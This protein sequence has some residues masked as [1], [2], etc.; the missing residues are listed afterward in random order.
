MGQ[1]TKF[2]TGKG[3]R[4]DTARLG[5]TERLPKSSLLIDVIGTLDEATCALGMARAHSQSTLMQGEFPE[6]Q[7]RLYRLMSH[8]SATPATRETY[9]GLTETDVE[10]LENFIAHLE[11]EVPQIQGF[12]LPGDSIA[13]AA[14]HMAR[15][16]VRRA[17][18]RLIT[19]SETE[20]GI[21]AP[22]LA[23]VNRLSS[24]LFVAALLE[25]SLVKE[26]PTMAKNQ[27]EKTL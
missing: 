22:N 17:E 14:C 8:I 27:A 13:G 15:G 11:G 1:K 7:R 21:G 20:P 19:F 18:R 6:I 25:D 4:G 3:D 5:D 23:F 2:Y 9:A 26:L 12:V 10:W 24:L 16:I